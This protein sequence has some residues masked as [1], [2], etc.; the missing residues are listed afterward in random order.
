MIN[1]FHG[2]F[3]FLSN[4]FEH[5]FWYKGMQWQTV[6]HAFQAA[7]CLNQADFNKVFVAETP[8]EAKRIGRKVEVIA[9]KVPG[10]NRPH[11]STALG[12]LDLA[13]ELE[14]GKAPTLMA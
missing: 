3:F 1:N 12:V 10:L 8:G 7:K 13:L 2:D 14:N 11:F 5:P 9:P 4:F 6:E